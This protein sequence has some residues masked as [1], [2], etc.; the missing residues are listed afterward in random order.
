MLCVPTDKEFACIWAV[1]PLK[2]AGCPIRTPESKKVTLPV[3]P[4]TTEETVAVSVT[5]LPCGVLIADDESAVVV[6]AGPGGGEGP[7]APPQPKITKITAANMAQIAGPNMFLRRDQ[8]IRINPARATQKH[9][10]PCNL[11]HVCC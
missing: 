1:P 3:A 11:C 10:R 2:D 6:D 5:A 9:V 4:P 7:P 8:P